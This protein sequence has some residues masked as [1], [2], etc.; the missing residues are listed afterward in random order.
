ML[1]VFLHCCLIVATM[2]ASVLVSGQSP[3]NRT[4]APTIY[5]VQYYLL[6]AQQSA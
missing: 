2:S 1:L 3:K 4:P 5:G 6:S